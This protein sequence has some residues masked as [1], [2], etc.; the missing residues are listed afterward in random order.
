MEQEERRGRGGHPHGAGEEDAQHRGGEK[1]SK[2]PARPA[3]RTGCW[4]FRCPEKAA[5]GFS[6]GAEAGEGKNG[7][8]SQPRA[9]AP[10]PETRP[11][12]PIISLD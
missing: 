12:S 9:G 5:M 6:R 11:I 10:C 1:P 8:P 3:S 4:C 7:P 2:V